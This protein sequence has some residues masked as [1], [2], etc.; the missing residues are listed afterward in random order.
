[1]N[2][3]YYVIAAYLAFGLY[4]T[5]GVMSGMKRP[6]RRIRDWALGGISMPV[7]FVVGLVFIAC[8][9][10]WARILPLL[11]FEKPEELRAGPVE[12]GQDKAA[13]KD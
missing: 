7:L 5:H 9:K 6:R 1:M 8:D 2:Y 13:P 12:P 3:W 11:D 4:L 10:L